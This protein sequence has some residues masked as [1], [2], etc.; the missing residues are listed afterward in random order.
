[1]EDSEQLFV[2]IRSGGGSGVLGGITALGDPAGETSPH[3]LLLAALQKNVKEIKHSSSYVTTMSCE[4]YLNQINV[5][6]RW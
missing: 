6:S 2:V 1:M 5:G 3:K 4:R